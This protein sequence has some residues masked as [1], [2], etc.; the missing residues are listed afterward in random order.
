MGPLKQALEP[1]AF[2][3][4]RPKLGQSVIVLGYPLQGLL[5]SS[6]NVTTGA[7]SALAG[8][9]DDTRLIQI[10]APVQPGNSGGPLLDQTGAVI[11]VVSSK[12]DALK[13]QELVGDV[14]ENVNFAIRDAVIRS[15][16]DVHGIEYAT[17]PSGKAL[18]TV[19]I[20]ERGE[21]AVVRI[22]CRK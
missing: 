20:T 3:A 16:L 13:T 18:D 17:A 5:A 22:E 9:G 12:L 19:A 11:G 21:K 10:S 4:E 7:V 1:L 15:F 8:P 14:P 2:S 6:V